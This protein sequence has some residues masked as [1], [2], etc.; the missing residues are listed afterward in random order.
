MNK[1]LIIFFIL[2]ILLLCFNLS[3]ADQLKVTF[4]NPGYPGAIFWDRVTDVMQAAANDLEIELT[5]LYAS[6]DTDTDRITHAAL[7]KQVAE[8][9][10]KP[11]YLI[12]IFRKGSTRKV[13]SSIEKHNLDTFIINTDVPAE[14]KASIGK[15]RQI[16]SHWIGH[17]FPNDKKAGYDLASE[18]INQATID[19]RPFHLQSNE[20]RPGGIVV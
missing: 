2:P 15:P 6:K 8:S 4:I 19:P 12:T 18:L 13:L 14:I 20:C 1:R 17:I 11:D 16:Y 9:P 3:Y 5:V 10:Q 7:V